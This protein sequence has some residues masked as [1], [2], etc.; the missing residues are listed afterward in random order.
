[1]SKMLHGFSID[2]VGW[3]LI[4]ALFDIIMYVR[5]KGLFF[6]GSKIED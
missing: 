4:G 6:V 1:M 2:G 5:A 3:D